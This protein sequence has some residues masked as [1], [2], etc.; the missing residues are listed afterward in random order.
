MNLYFR[1]LF[2]LMKAFWGKKQ[3][4][5]SESRLTFRVLPF[6]C[7]INFHLNNARYF[8]FMDLGRIQLLGQG[9][10]LIPLYQRRKMPVITGAEISFIKALA[11]WQQFK[12]V[13][14]ILGWD[15][16]YIYIEQ[17]F[18]TSNGLAAV[19]LVKG[20]FVTK[21]KKG[22]AQEIMD[23]I[24]PGIHSPELPSV[25]SHWQ[26]LTDVKKST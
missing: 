12:L 14:R 24:E 1:F 6:D 9:R 26:L 22:K 5:F 7:D 19:A 2:I 18:E 10:L 15:E 16:Y 21:G 25:I 8:S 4:V 11:P 23:L 17:R 20:T 13:S 3:G